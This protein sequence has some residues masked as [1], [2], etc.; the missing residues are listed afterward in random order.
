MAEAMSQVREEYCGL[1]G[2]VPFWSSMAPGE[3]GQNTCTAAGRQTSLLT[4]GGVASRHAVSREPAFGVPAPALSGWRVFEQEQA[5]D[6]S[7]IRTYGARGSFRRS[8]HGAASDGSALKSRLIGSNPAGLVMRTSTGIDL[9]AQ[10]TAEPTLT[11]SRSGAS[12]ALL[13]RF[14][15]LLAAKF[16]AR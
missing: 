13:A 6:A 8:G 14:Q 12:T 9:C 11:L 16:S 5:S 15:N 7:Q 10:P 3:E 4:S 1:D 2:R